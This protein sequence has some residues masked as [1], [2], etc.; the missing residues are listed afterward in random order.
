MPL[1]LAIASAWLAPLGREESG[2]GDFASRAIGDLFVAGEIRDPND[3]AANAT[4]ATAP[5]DTAAIVNRA[6]KETPELP[7]AM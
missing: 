2:D 7:P 4:I 3:R 6:R 5:I 1:A